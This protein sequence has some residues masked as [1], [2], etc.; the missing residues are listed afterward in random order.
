MAPGRPSPGRSSAGGPHRRLR[1][2][3]VGSERVADALQRPA[4]TD[5]RSAGQGF[6]EESGADV[7]V[8]Y[9]EDEGLASQIEQEGD[10]SPADV[11]LTENTPPLEALAEKELLAEVD[12]STLDEVPSQYSSPSGHWVGVAARETVMVYNPDADRRRRTAGL[13]PRPRQ[14]RMEGQAGDRPL[15]ARLRADRQRDRRSSTAKR[16][17]RAGSKASPTTP[18]ATTTTR[19]SSPPSTA[20]RSPPG[21]S[22]TTT[23]TRR[24]PRKARTRCPPSSTTSA[25]KTPARWS[26]SPA[27]ARSSRAATPSSRRNSS[28]TWSA[29]K[30]RPR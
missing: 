1:L 29:R 24:W 25:T 3:V 20:V 5:D 15:R 30:A 9:G 7:Q 14:A 13:D 18:S 26:T 22:T 21:S 28:P 23:G 10:A 16:R 4:R 8:R 2:L 6:E 27:P 12:S 19:G 17:R 11:V